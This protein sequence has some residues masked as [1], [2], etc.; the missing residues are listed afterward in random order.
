MSVTQATSR[1][2]GN[3]DG[4]DATTVVPVFQDASDKST[5]QNDTI[6]PSDD[7]CLICFWKIITRSC[8]LCIIAT[9]VVLT[10]LIWFIIRSAM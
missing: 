2:D 8:W 5:P 3:T 4:E 7:D 9:A 10:L 6:K 1:M